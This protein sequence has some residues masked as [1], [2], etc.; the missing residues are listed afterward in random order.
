MVSVSD[1]LSATNDFAERKESKD[2]D[3]ADTELD[4]VRHSVRLDGLKSSLGVL[5]DGAGLCLKEFVNRLDLS[6]SGRSHAFL[7]VHLF[8]ELADDL[9]PEDGLLDKGVCSVCDT[10]NFAGGGV[11]TDR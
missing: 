2:L 5:H 1:N 7:D 11:V 3:G 8:G 10:G 4:S 6:G 9:G